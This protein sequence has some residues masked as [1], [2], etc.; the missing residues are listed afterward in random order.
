MGFLFP[1]G[2]CFF[3]QQFHDKVAV[4]IKR[5]VHAHAKRKVFLG[6]AYEDAA[7]RTKDGPFKLE[8]LPFALP[9]PALDRFAVAPQVRRLAVL[10]QFR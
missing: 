4:V 1:T 6:R 5:I 3:R 10:A 8:S 7:S 2:F 9:G